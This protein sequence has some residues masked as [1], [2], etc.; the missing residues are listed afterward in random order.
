MSRDHSPADCDLTRALEAAQLAY[1]TSTWPGAREER[2][3]RAERA[4]P[5]ADKVPAADAALVC[6]CGLPRSAPAVKVRTLA[7]AST[8]A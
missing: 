4:L 7:S 5:S 6:L 8:S 2:E 1:A 3:A